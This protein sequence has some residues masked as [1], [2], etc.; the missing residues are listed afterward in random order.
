[1]LAMKKLLSFAVALLVLG[2]FAFGQTSATQ[3]GTAATAVVGAAATVASTDMGPALESLKATVQEDY[4]VVA[5]NTLKAVSA[6]V[7]GDYRYWPIV[8][9]TNKEAIA[10]PEL[11]EPGM[12]FKIYTLP[13]DPALPNDI[14]KLLIAETYL[15]TYARYVE[16][17]GEWVD[18]RRW[19]LLEATHFA[20]DLF[21]RFDG[22]ID[23]SDAAWYRGR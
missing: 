12:A 10:N 5:G 7:Y 1:M 22:R 4:S 13:F 8:Y 19:V 6:A 18:A 21:T 23:S 11:V 20:P 3:P 16:L 14:S 17:G 15:Q 2:S 9:L